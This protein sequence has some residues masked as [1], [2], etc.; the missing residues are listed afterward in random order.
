[1]GS[2]IRIA[3]MIQDSIVDGPGFRFVLFTQGCPHNC[4]GCHN[5]G[6]WDVDGGREADTD[7][8]IAAIKKNPLTDGVTLSG[9]EPFIQ[10]GPCAEI[11][12]AA[13]ESGLNIWVYSGYTF[14][15]LMALGGDAEKLL[16]LTDVLIDGRFQIEEKT[17]TAKWRGSSNQRVIDVQRSIAEG[18]AVEL[19][20]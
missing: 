5:P 8:I 3:D 18:T 20:T 12:A 17:Y 6:T 13:K 11:A 19:A 2:K 10:A 14:E 15:E 1:M 4:S 9:G 7:E 16:R